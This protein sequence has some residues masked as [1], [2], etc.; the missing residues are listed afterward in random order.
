[1]PCTY[2]GSLAGDRAYFAEERAEAAAKKVAKLTRLL[3]EAMKKL[4]SAQTHPFAGMVP[5]SKELARWWK[6]HKKIDAN[7]EAEEARARKRKKKA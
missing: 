4:E 5:V 1:M 7:R 6:L 2:T 3:C